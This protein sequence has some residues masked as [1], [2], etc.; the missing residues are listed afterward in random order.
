MHVHIYILFLSV[1]PTEAVLLE[2]VGR[3]KLK[4]AVMDHCG[5]YVS[6]CLPHVFKLLSK[7][8]GNRV[9]LV[10]V[11]PATPPL[12]GTSS[13]SGFACHLHCL[14]YGFKFMFE[15]NDW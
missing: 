14:L 12:V 15:I 13:F 6:A 8:L 1:W 7:A 4:T 10:A 5:D 2:M 11:K 9:K 3:M